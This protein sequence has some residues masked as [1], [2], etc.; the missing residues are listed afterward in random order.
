MPQQEDEPQL[1]PERK[2]FYDKLD[3]RSRKIG[4]IPTLPYTLDD[5][6]ERGTVIDIEEMKVLGYI[7]NEY[8][9]RIVERDSDQDEV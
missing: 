8:G 1:S 5:M 9:I 2:R 3:A 6:R 7:V 4:E